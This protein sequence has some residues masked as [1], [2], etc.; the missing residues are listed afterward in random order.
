M[1]EQTDAFAQNLVRSHQ[2]LIQMLFILLSIVHE[3]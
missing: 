2:V 1:K 3:M